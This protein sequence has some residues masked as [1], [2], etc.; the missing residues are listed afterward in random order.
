MPPTKDD[1]LLK[2]VFTGG[3]MCLDFVATLGRR[4]TLDVER[5]PD[6]ESL[7]RWLMES[8][9]MRGSLDP[10]A[11]VVE[12]SR[13]HD[14]RE[15]IYRL[16]Q[17]GLKGRPFA[18]EDVRFVNEVAAEPDL[19]PQLAAGP[20][21]GTGVLVS[22]E[23]AKGPY[24]VRAALSTIA[25]DTIQLLTSSLIGRV[26]ECEAD[27]CSLL[28]LDD[29]QARRRRWC[30]MGRCGNLAKITKYRASRSQQSKPRA[31]H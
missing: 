5:L 11:T 15:G 3:R 9:I 22:A 16:L 1:P 20:E 27:T 6:A 10:Q 14:L 29:S 8:G 30:S 2:F 21:P 24:A 26:K 19:P 23:W 25:R 18:P 28:F 31:S 13:A 7:D 4:G 12:L 17:A